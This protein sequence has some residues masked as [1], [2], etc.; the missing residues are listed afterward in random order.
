MRVDGPVTALTA[1]GFLVGVFEEAAY[2]TSQAWLAP[3]DALFLYTDGVTEAVNAVG[4][5]FGN[6]GLEEALRAG[7][8][9]EELVEHRHRRSEAVCSR[10]GAVGRSDRAGGAPRLRASRERERPEVSDLRSL[11]LPARQN[12]GRP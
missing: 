5:Y 10:R 7:G 3:G 4:S 2:E 1:H 6:E 8:S 11:T 12:R 9:P